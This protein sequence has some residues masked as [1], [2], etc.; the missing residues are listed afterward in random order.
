MNVRIYHTAGE[1]GKAA[2]TVVSSQIIVNP[3]SVLGLA[4]GA[5]PIPTYRELIRLYRAGLVDFSMATSF[6]LDE[7]IGLTREHP[8]SYYYFMQK[9]LFESINLPQTA[10]HVPCGTAA[11]T[12]EECRHYDEMITEAGGIDLQILGIGNNGHIAFN[13][14]CDS[15]PVGTH[16]VALTQSTID[17]NTRFFDNSEEVP[18]FAISMG[19]GSIIRAR[20]IVLIA[21]GK[22]KAQA[23]HDMIQGPVP[24]RCPASILQLHP[25]VTVFADD[26]AASLL[27]PG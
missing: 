18:R 10:I 27:C 19:I 3:R 11:N 24:P 21:I 13:E 17:A 20:Q 16:K 8:E 6:N 25:N 23:V 12:E 9:N 5:S 15:F 7:Y 4:T 2:A 1:I 14:P 22:T 26:A